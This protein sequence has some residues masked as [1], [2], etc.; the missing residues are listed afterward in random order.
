MSAK[1]RRSLLIF[2]FGFGTY[3]VLL[4][5]L[6]P[7]PSLALAGVVAALAVFVDRWIRMRRGTPV[8]QSPDNTSKP[9]Q[10]HP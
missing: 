6:G 10:S 8:T 1:T 3:A 9:G 4:S 5:T 2:V 7:L